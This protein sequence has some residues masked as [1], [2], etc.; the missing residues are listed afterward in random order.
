M[1]RLQGGL[2]V[3]NYVALRP[4]TT[5]ENVTSCRRIQWLR[6]IGHGACH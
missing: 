5:D 1:M 2:Q 4:R 6:F 3:D